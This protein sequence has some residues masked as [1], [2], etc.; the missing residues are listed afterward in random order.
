MNGSPSEFMHQMLTSLM[1]DNSK[2]LLRNLYYGSDRVGETIR[3]MVAEELDLCVRFYDDYGEDLINR[4]LDYI[5]CTCDHTGENKG[6]LC[7]ECDND[8]K[9]LTQDIRKI[10]P[11]ALGGLAGTYGS[12]STSFAPVPLHRE[13]SLFLETKTDHTQIRTG[14]RPTGGIEK[15]N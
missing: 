5:D 2:L 14:V 12:R 10:L 8:R 15:S 11:D 13:K 4:L 1:S 6:E 9:V 3:P 7:T